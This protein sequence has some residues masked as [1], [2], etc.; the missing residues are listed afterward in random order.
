MSY[1]STFRKYA[2]RA[3]R[4]VKKR[5]VKKGG[6]LNEKRIIKDVKF[7]K[8][9]LNSEKKRYTIN[10]SSATPLGQVSGNINGGLA[11]DITPL[12]QQGTGF[13]TRNGSSI[14]L[15]SSYL[16]FQFYHQ[17]QTVAPIR[18]KIYIFEI[19]GATQA[20]ITNVSSSFLSVNPF[21]YAGNSP[22]VAIYD[23]NSARNPDFMK[24]YRLIKVKTATVPADTLSTQPMIKDVKIGLKYKNLH[25]RFSADSQTVTSGQLCCLIV[26][27]CG[28]SG[29]T[30]SSVAL[31]P[32]T[33]ATTGLSVNYNFVH[34][35]YDN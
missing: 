32:A 22:A 27:D 2:R 31:I 12:P 11:L 14:K 19:K 35:F 3:Q 21:I 10:N 16:Q 9:V 34:Y 20:P 5:Y 15:H 30:A 24:Q 13:S 7:L 8:S 4:A 29:T 18:V 26:T 25:T 6:K 23:Y 1:Y 28:N 33:G 17:A